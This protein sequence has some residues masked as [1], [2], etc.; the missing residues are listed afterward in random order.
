MRTKVQST[1]LALTL[2]ATSLIAAC[3]EEAPPPAPTA[4]P[5]PQKDVIRIGHVTSQ[6]GPFASGVAVSSGP[7]YD[8]WVA[9]VNERGGIYVAE[10]GKQLPIEYIKYDDGS[11]LAEMTRLLEQAILEDDLD[12]IFPPWGTSF[13][14]SAAPI[15]DQYGYILI[16]GAGGAVKLKDLRLPYFFQV[17]NFSETQMPVLAD[18]LVELGVKT[19]AIIFIGDL[20]GI[21][22]S[23]VAVPELANRGIEV[24]MIKS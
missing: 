14:Y 10:Y 20:H 4:P 6:T 22:Y 21:E 3:R 23:G 11:D 18:V 12:F 1:L 16:G 15:A 2:L 13:L 8:M 24:K 17:L 19:V 5:L 7:V 9:E